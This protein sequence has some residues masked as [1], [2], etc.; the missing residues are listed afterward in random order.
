MLRLVIGIPLLIHGLAHISGFLA[1]YTSA[2]VGFKSKPWIFSESVYIHNGM[3]RLFGILWLLAMGCFSASG[4]MVLFLQSGWTH[5]A[6]SGAALSLI[7]IVPWWRAVPA[8]AKMG[9]LF[10]TVILITFLTPMR[11]FLVNTLSL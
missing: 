10:D 11:D 2:D 9:V 8:G 7:S 4:M 1:A 3:G 5:Y 6:L